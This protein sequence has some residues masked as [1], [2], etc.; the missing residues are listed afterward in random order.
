MR[1]KY[2]FTFTASDTSAAKQLS[3][4][5]APLALVTPA[6]LGATSITFLWCET[7]SGTYIPVNDHTGAAITVTV[8]TSAAGLADLTTI[9]PASV[10]LLGKLNLGWLKLKAGASITASVDVIAMDV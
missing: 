9:F 8:S 10:S 5:G 4:N 6:S 1:D 7:A 3:N 2:T